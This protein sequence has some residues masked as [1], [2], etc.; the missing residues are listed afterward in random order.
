LRKAVRSVEN[1]VTAATC[2]HDHDEEGGGYT[3]RQAAEQ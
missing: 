2:G 3:G 1:I